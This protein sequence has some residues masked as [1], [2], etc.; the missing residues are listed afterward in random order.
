MVA[1]TSGDKPRP[2]DMLHWLAQAQVQGQR[3]R[4]NEFRQPETR[5]A[6]AHLHYS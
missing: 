5:V 2:Q 6:L 3:E 4:G 1:K